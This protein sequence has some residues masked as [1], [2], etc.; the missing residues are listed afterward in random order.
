MATA[1][2]LN[3]ATQD[4]YNGGLVLIINLIYAVEILCFCLF[5]DEV[6][7]TTIFCFRYVKK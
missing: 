2:L 1:Q 3:A 6:A 5:A 4:A 7:S